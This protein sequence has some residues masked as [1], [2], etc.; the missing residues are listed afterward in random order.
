MQF[1]RIST[2]LLYFRNRLTYHQL[3]S[4]YLFHSLFMQNQCSGGQCSLHSMQGSCGCG[5]QSSCACSSSCGC[6]GQERCSCGCGASGNCP[7]GNLMDAVKC[8]KKSLL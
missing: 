6:G 1:S 5:G 8:A 3:R 2:H 7:A 4:F